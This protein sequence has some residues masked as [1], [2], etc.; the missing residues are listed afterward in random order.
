M[1]LILAATLT[2]GLLIGAPVNIQSRTSVCTMGLHDLTAKAMDGT[3]VELKSL[4][5]KNVIA[6]NVASK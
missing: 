5:G 2:S 3:D 4:A 6:L 1:A